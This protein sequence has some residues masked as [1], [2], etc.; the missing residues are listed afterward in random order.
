MLDFVCMCV[1][2]R[3][4]YLRLAVCNCICACVTACSNCAYKVCIRMRVLID[5]NV[6]S[7]NG[8]RSGLPAGSSSRQYVWR[9]QGPP[10]PLRPTD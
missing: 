3:L 4:V 7:F 2:L 10:E 6:T 9:Q 5:L 1:L 8:I